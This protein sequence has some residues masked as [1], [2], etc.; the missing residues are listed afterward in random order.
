[1][2]QS[3]ADS[4][5]RKL[6]GIILGEH[7][8]DYGDSLL[9]QQQSAVFF[10]FAWNPVLLDW[11]RM[12]EMSHYDGEVPVDSSGV[13]GCSWEF[14]VC[15]CL[16][17]GNGVP[18]LGIGQWAGEGADPCLKTP[19]Y[20][21]SSAKPQ[22]VMHSKTPLGFG[23]VVKH[24]ASLVR[25]GFCLRKS[26]CLLVGASWSVRNFPNRYKKSSVGEELMASKLWIYSRVSK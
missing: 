14:T 18:L 15:A 25:D 12:T 26:G 21:E 11:R 4:R 2:D 20:P 6:I 16:Q 5:L 7:F 3:D 1:M 17:I 23:W 13:E 10:L 22:L 9:I 19:K 24:K 8:A